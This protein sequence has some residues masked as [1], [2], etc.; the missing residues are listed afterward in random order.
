MVAPVRSAGL[1]IGIAVAVAIGCLGFMVLA[2]F[3]VT[4]S[5]MAQSGSNK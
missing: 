2:V 1:R 3:V 4:M 5:L